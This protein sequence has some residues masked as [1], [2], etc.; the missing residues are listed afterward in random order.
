M[1][2]IPFYIID[3]KMNMMMG[4]YDKNGKLCTR[5]MEEVLSFLVDKTPIQILD[6]SLKYINSDLRAAIASAKTIVPSTSMVPVVINPFHEIV[7]FSHKSMNNEDAIIFNEIK[8]YN[9]MAQGLKTKVVFHS[10]HSILVDARLTPF[11]HKRTAAADLR[12]ITASRLRFPERLIFKPESTHEF[13][14]GANGKY[15]F[16]ALEEKGEE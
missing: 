5:V 16:K 13:K 2:I 10:G 6:E 12:K 7:V 1:R 11:N 4:E 14:K 8:I 3:K 15:N 9:T